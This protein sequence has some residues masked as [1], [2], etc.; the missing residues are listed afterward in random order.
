MQ[1]KIVFQKYSYIYINILNH[2]PTELFM[3]KNRYGD[4]TDLQ[5]YNY[6]FVPL[7][8]FFNQPII[9]IPGIFL[10]SHQSA[11]LMAIGFVCFHSIFN[12]YAKKNKIL[13]GSFVFIIFLCILVSFI[14]MPMI[15]IIIYLLYFYW[16]KIII[17]PYRLLI[18]AFL[19]ILLGNI[20]LPIY[21]KY[22]ILIKTLPSYIYSSKAES[23]NQYLTK[24][25]II[26]IFTGNG[27][28]NPLTAYKGLSGD[29]FFIFFL[30]DQIGIIGVC[31]YLTIFFSVLF[32]KFRYT[33][34]LFGLKHIIMSMKG[35][36]LIGLFS[37]FHY[38]TIMTYS[39]QAIT[40]ASVGTLYGLKWWEKY[41]ISS[42]SN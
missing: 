28:L 39:I 33:E 20:F 8:Y 26:T 23:I 13:L 6:E 12:N 32:Y 16:K 35:I 38:S 15:M 19:I 5:N 27:Y 3:V 7:F 30:T 25:N 17:K 14:K 41:F 40:Y 4:P 21:Q 2:H 29:D 22:A 36:I 9:R 11:H 18:P 37:T 24:N 1:T 34:I 31:L 10:Q 42:S